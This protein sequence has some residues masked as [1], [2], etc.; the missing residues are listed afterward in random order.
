M[1]KTPSSPQGVTIHGEGLEEATTS[2]PELVVEPNADLLSQ[3]VKASIQTQYLIAAERGQISKIKAWR[4]MRGFDQASLAARANMTQ[5]EVSRA[6]RL[7]QVAKMKG[8]TLR[9][10]AQA[11]QVRIDDLF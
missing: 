9:R 8:E 2:P 11:L 1:L 10:I 7:G 5:P 3:Q 4:I 6:E